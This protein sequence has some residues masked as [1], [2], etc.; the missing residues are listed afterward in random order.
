MKKQMHRLLSLM[1]SLILVVGM[2]PGTMIAHAAETTV[3]EITE[4]P[5]LTVGDTLRVQTLKDA[6]PSIADTDI[7][8]V[9][10]Y[11][12]SGVATVVT[13]VK[14]ENKDKN[15]YANFVWYVSRDTEAVVPNPSD[16]IVKY[17]GTELPHVDSS[18]YGGNSWYRLYKDSNGAIMCQ[19][20]I[21]LGKPSASQP[22][23]EHTY[24]ENWSFD[25]RYHWRAAT[26][27]HTT[28]KADYEKH[29]LVDGKCKCGFEHTH[30]WDTAWSYNEDQHWH[31]C[32]AENCPAYFV[33]DRDGWG[34]HNADAYGNC[35]D[36]G[37]P[38]FT[39]SYSVQVVG[40][41][42]DKTEYAPGETVTITA[43][44]PVPGKQF[45]EWTGVDG[46]TF[47]SGDKN[48]A[49]ASFTMPAKDVRVDAQWVDDDSVIY[50]VSNATHDGA[51]KAAVG[52]DFVVKFTPAEGYRMTITQ[53]VVKVNSVAKNYGTDWTF[54][55][56]TNTLTIKA[57]AIDG[58]IIIEAH[59][60]KIPT[61]WAVEYD[62]TNATHNGADK[63]A[64]GADF[65]VKFTPAE[66]Y[67]MTVTQM[68]VKV[69]GVT[70]DMGTDWTFDTETNTLTIKA[71]AIDGNLLIF[72]DAVSI[73]GAGNSDIP[74]TGDNSNMFLWSALLFVSGL[75]LVATAFG[76]KRFSVK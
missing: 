36:C 70:Q 69:G 55:T 75:G 33:H 22:E 30:D 54:D 63:A 26:C 16:Y 74:Q 56:E 3:V 39:P 4:L 46:L 48:S 52:A 37:M 64:V 20:Y 66:G 42:A 2:I 35:S 47:T 11:V 9:S 72:A 31:N 21:K 34:F 7:S 27:E 76:K 44:D 53:M 15:H 25:T 23:H 14:E 41:N 28:E 59:A 50:D 49:T 5:S 1:L 40:G 19:V 73:N 13:N 65:V 71:A 29:T 67:K 8:K 32:K 10:Y 57:A 58:Y 24:S 60:E 62:V 45:K 38:M 61:E 68:V 43:H 51:D 18:S 6:V 17:D 12:Y